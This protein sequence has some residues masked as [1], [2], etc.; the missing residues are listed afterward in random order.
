VTGGRDAEYPPAPV[1]ERPS[2]RSLRANIERCRACDLWEPAT[3]PVLGE[4]PRRAR[5]VMVGEQPG[6]REDIEGRPF[7]G[8]AG[9]VLDRALERAGIER[10]DAYVTNAVKHFRFRQRGKRR[11]HQTPDRWHVSACLPWLDAEL[12]LIRPEAVVC[13]GAVAARG[14]LGS[15]VRIGRDR[16]RALDSELAELVTITA[17]PASILRVR[18]QAGRDAAFDALVADLSSVADWLGGH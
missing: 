6:D 12:K 14:L 1:P 2:L 8:P 9:S 15:Q 13:L 11:I 5:V 7:V 16:G 18:E 10:S 4:G 3:Q 17:H